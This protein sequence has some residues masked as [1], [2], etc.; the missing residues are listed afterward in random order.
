MDHRNNIRRRL[1]HPAIKKANKQLTELGIDPIGN[2]TPHGLRRSFASLRAASGDDPA[3][4]AAQLGHEDPTFT[5]RVY[6]HA[7]KR[8][9][10]LTKAEKA[11]Y[12]RALEW[13]RWASFGSSAETATPAFPAT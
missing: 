5:L 11:E 6:T 4:T 3:Y 2:V 13:A 9:D 1:F 7:V 12:D 10:R 8:R